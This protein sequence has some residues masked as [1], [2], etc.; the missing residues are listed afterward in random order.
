MK[1][2]VPLSGGL[3]STSLVVS[4]LEKGNIV[5]A[6]YFQIDNNET[7]VV[8]EKKTRDMFREHSYFKSFIN[9]GKLIVT[10]CSP[11]VCLCN[12]NPMDLALTQ[13]AVWLFSLLYTVDDSIDEVQLAYVLNDCAV[14]WIN[15]IQAI[16]K[17]YEGLTQSGKLP[18]LSF[19]YIKMPKQEVIRVLNNVDYG[20]AELTWSC[21]MPVG[22][23]VCG[24]CVPCKRR[25]RDN[26]PTA[27][28]YKEDNVLM[29]RLIND[30]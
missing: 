25:D 7:K 1:V 30:N 9:R 4:N 24:T 13:P 19:P 23:K 17:A 21:E 22:E 6:P 28:H 15:E 16:W 12:G 8:M 18:T 10:D 3:D 2:M 20:I 29:G 27:S 14:S 11:K 5:V 26:I